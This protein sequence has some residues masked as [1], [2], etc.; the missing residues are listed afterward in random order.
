MK[1][2]VFL[3]LIITICLLLSVSCTKG[4]DTDS[5]IES[6]VS[7]ST[8]PETADNSDTPDS[9][10][11]ES[12]TD[13]IRV[14]ES[15]TTEEPMNDPSDKHEFS[16]EAVSALV[17]LRQGMVG[18]P[19]MFAVAYLGYANSINST[20]IDDYLSSSCPTLS[21]DLPFISEIPSENIIG[22]GEGFLFCIV[23]LDENATIAVNKITV[24]TDSATVFEHILYRSEAGDPILIF[25]DRGDIETDTE[26]IITDSDG[27]TVSWFPR[28]T[29]TG[30]I[31]TSNS[32]CSETLVFDFSPYAEHLK[33]EYAGMTTEF[34]TLPTVDQLLNTD[35]S[36]EQ[37][38]DNG[39][40][41]SFSVSIREDGA[42]VYWNNDGEDHE[43]SQAECSIYYDE[44]AAILE[45]DFAEFAGIQRCA[46]LISTEE[47]LL[48][49]C[50]NFVDGE[51][52]FPES[53][54]AA[55]T[56]ERTY[57]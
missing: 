53:G 3:T 34:W 49:T 26:V 1:K 15:E 51:T 19:N 24:N 46:V 6:S 9:T 55:R 12:E 41:H 37:Y 17:S 16:T 4:S 28:I 27:N 38:M 5:T 2:T 39:D 29:D 56:L 7:E 42:Y 35:W 30:R 13:E 57:G 23:P 32:T 10:D 45:F 40:V 14:T 44:G 33:A 31:E 50:A 11:N 54:I 48:Y 8:D 22:E 18:T 20:A 52:E 43:Y 36:C 47:N 25:T 21:N